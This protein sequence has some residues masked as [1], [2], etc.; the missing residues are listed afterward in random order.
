MNV[1]NLQPGLSA[2]QIILNTMLGPPFT[3]RSNRASFQIALSTSAGTDYQ[4]SI[5]R[6]GHI[7]T[8]WLQDPSGKI[9][10]LAGALSL[11][12]T[13][14]MR[15]PTEVAPQYDDNQGN[16]TFRFNAVPDQAYVATFDHQQKAILLTSYAQ[17]FG[18]VADEFAHVF[19]TGMLS[20][21]AMLVN[22]ARFPIWSQQF[23][24]NLL[25][26]QDGLDDQAKIIF[27]GQWDN[28]VRT[29]MRNQAS[30]QEGL[31]ARK[32]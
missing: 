14:T 6:L 21:C 5:P 30:V 22:D 31:G 1:N 2:A 23:V 15:A 13:S 16:I 24:S 28:F 11:A 3:W 26:A 29:A 4:L 10:Q 25:G 27:M 9:H 8:Q 20:W 32:R 18:P 19:F 12:K 17:N 7:E